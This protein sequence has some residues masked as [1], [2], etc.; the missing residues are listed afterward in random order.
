MNE[1]ENMIKE[2]ESL[3]ANTPEG[4]IVDSDTILGDLIENSDFEFNGF[5]QDIFNIWKES[6]DKSAVEQMFYGFTGVEFVEYLEKCKSEIS[7]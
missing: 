6:K 3:N 7:R 5:S 4:C 2:V 1:I